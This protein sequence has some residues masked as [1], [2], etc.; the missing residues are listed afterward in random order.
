MIGE[1][2][3]GKYEIVKRIGTGGTADVYKARCL[4]DKNTFVAI[5]VLKAEHQD[6]AEYVRRFGREAQA[7]MKLRHKNIVKLIGT[8]VENGASY[9]VFEYIDGPT[10]KHYILEQG[11]FE[12]KR[13]ASI[14][15]NILDAI[16]YAHSEGIIHRDVK[17]Q[18]IMI[19]SDLSLIHI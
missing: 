1:K 13:A 12:P 3:G 14:I 4:D 11:K 5:K 6:N 19:T 17:P 7:C 9:I 8:G 18:N 10:L 16:G 2:I 15:G